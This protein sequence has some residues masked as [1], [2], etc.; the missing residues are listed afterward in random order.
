M[1]YFGSPDE[2]HDLRDEVKDLKALNDKLVDFVLGLISEVDG[3]DSSLHL[4]RGVGP[5]EPPSKELLPRL[6]SISNIS[7]EVLRHR[8]ET[9]EAAQ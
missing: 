9:L 7:V 3:L 5:W 6:R 2:L 8:M 1:S 4:E